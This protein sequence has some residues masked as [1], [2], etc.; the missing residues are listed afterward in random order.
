M[1][2]W[3]NNAKALIYG[4]TRTTGRNE[5]IKAALESIS[6]QI[7]AILDSM[8][9][10]SGL[11][12]KELRADGG[13]TKNDYLMQLQ[14]DLSNVTVRISDTEELS[15]LGAAYMAGIS[16][17]LYKKDDIF[18]KKQYT[19]YYPKMQDDIRKEK[20]RRWEETIRLV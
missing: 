10:D 8:R 16:Y 1:P 6:M 11:E 15:A 3:K 9:K 7:E 18:C 14:S 13:P 20:I 12:I 4:M 19:Y 17:G 5:L 2:Y